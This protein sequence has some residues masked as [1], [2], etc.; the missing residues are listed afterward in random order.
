[1][2]VYEGRSGSLNPFGIKSSFVA[3]RPPIYEQEEND[4]EEEE[5]EYAVFDVTEL[6]RTVS[7]AL[8]MARSRSLN[9]ESTYAA[10]T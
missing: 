5:E 10:P 4:D 3:D 9:F 6:T 2:I 1:M 8:L 7:E